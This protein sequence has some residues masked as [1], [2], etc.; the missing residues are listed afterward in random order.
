MNLGYRN[1]EFNRADQTLVIAEI[2]VNHNGDLETARKL[3]DA[4]ARAGVDAVKFQ[5]F[6]A[7]KEIS[8][9][10]VKAPYQEKSVALGA[11]QLEMCKALELSGPALLEMKNY[12]ASIKMSFLCTAFDFDSVDLLTDELKVETIK[13]PSGE[14]TNF[15]LLTYIA[16]KKKA[17][18]LSTGASNLAEVGM[19]VETLQKAGCPE[20]IIFHCVSS[21]PA[22]FD[23]L[24]LRAMKALQKGFGLPVGFSDH[25]TGIYA[26]ITA[27]ALGAVAVE[28]HFTLDRK[29]VGPDHQAS[30]EPDEMAELVKGIQI[31]NS[32]LGSPLKKPSPCEIA[33]LPFIRKSLVAAVDLQQGSVLSREMIEI[34]RPLGGIE[35]GD[36]PKIIGRTLKNAVREDAPITWEDLA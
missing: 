13:I 12:C 36:L 4:A 22:L 7:E 26:A 21:Y 16:N 29:M 9:H 17:V 18:I 25:S 28:K 1:F 19:A 31:A 30:I 32:A 35:P 10:A 33:N 20:L 6:R 8:R 2:G 14:I 27:A 5:A 34:K 11:N 15:P 23:C 3:V 24:N